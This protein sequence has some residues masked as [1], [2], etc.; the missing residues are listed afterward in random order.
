MKP[1]GAVLRYSGG[2]PSIN[3]IIFL[4]GRKDDEEKT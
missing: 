1:A 4:E 3:P 2:L